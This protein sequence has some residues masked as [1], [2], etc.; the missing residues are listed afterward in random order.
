M[1]GREREG[2]SRCEGERREEYGR[3]EARWEGEKE[4]GSRGVRERKG[5]GD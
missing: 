4:R 3:R 2:E 5:G 1:L